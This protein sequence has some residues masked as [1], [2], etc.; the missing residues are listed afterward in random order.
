ENR[1]ADF[2]RTARAKGLRERVIA[3]RHLLRASL[4]PVVALLALQMGFLLGGAVLTEMLFVRPGLGQLTLT[5]VQ[6]RDYPVVQAVI[7]LSAAVYVLAGLAADVLTAWL[8]PRQ[9]AERA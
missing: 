6:E 3:R 5:A 1:D 2:V 9:R 8:D 7:T 4:G